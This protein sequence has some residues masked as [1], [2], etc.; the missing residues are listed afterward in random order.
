MRH[1]L[2]LIGALLL[3]ACGGGG[4]DGAS[5]AGDGPFA[6]GAVEITFVDDSRPTAANGD[7]PAKDSRMLFTRIY[8]PAVGAPESREV[9]GAAPATSDG[10][11]PLVVFAHGFQAVSEVYRDIY[12]AWAEAGYVVAAPDF[13]L[14]SSRS[15]MNRPVAS[16]YVNQ[17]ADVSFLI[18]RLLGESARGDGVLA[19]LV[20]PERIGV[21]GQSLGGMTTM[22]V[23]F[24]T[25]CVDERIDAAIPMAGRLAAFPDGEYF[26]G[27]DTPFLTILGGDHIIPY[28]AGRNH[29][30]TEPVRLASVAFLDAYL[31]GRR[32]ALERLLAV[33]D[34]AVATVEAV[35]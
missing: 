11:Y 6:V 15:T 5:P 25:C 1:R 35:P 29:P 16:D 27:I 14:S 7:V 2:A 33:D 19:G 28:V 17:P 30:Q 13:P 32:G 22:G 24:H 20:D 9:P 21:S 10:P 18:D 26:T 23:A 12:V 31:K 34:L 3:G 4:G 8:Y